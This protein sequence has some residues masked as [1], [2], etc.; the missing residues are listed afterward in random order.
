MPSEKPKSEY[1]TYKYIFQIEKENAIEH[2][3]DISRKT[4]TSKLDTAVDLPEWTKLEYKKCPN[5]GPKK[6]NQVLK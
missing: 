6:V 2:T 5:C 3:V 1:I 4:V